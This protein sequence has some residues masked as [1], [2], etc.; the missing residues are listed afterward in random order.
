MTEAINSYGATKSF[1]QV[2]VTRESHGVANDNLPI[3][4]SRSGYPPEFTKLFYD[5]F[6]KLG[7]L[8]RLDTV[9]IGSPKPR[10]ITCFKMK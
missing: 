10:V 8:V 1:G 5:K 7:D 4:H 2:S 3:S 9:V 6:V